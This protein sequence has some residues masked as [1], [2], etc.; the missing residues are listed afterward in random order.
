MPDLSFRVARTR[1]DLSRD[2]PAFV[3]LHRKSHAGKRKFMDDRMEAFFREMAEAF[4]EA[5]WLRLA[6]LSAGREDV[7]AAFQL[8]W[9]GTLLLYHSGFDPA[10]RDAS[11]GL[12]LLARCIEDAIRLGMREYDFLRGRERYKYDLGGRD[13]IVCRATVRLP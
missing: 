5:G 12:V 7:A 3:A 10:R 4:F 2:F 13:R 9:R 8:A 6:F 11:P 1:E